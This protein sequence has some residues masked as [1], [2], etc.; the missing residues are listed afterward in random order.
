MAVELDAGQ[1][2]RFQS[3]VASAEFES[4]E[5]AYKVAL[6]EVL[7]RIL[8]PGA[9]DQPESAQRLADFFRD[10]LDLAE[11]G[12]SSEDADAIG[13]A[14]APLGGI[15]G[16]FANLCG[17]R[18]GVNNFVWIPGAI[19]AGLG[20]PTLEAFARLVDEGRP[21]ADRV[22]QFRVDL[23]EVEERAAGGSGWQEQWHVIDIQLAFVAALLGAL[24]PQRYTFYQATLLREAV[25]R[26]GG[27]WPKG[28]AG[29]RYAAICEFV[30][31]VRFQLEQ[32]GAS[33]RDLIDVQSFLFL[34]TQEGRGEERTPRVWIVRAG[35]HGEGEEVALSNDAAVI[36]WRELPDLSGYPDFP[37]IKALYTEQFP[38][39]SPQTISKQAS[40]IDRFVHELRV[41]DFVLLPRVLE[42]EVVAVGEV[43]GDYEYHPEAPFFDADA[44]H[45]RPVD[46][47]DTAVPRSSFDRELRGRLGLTGT[48][49]QI[50]LSDTSDRVRRALGEPSTE[51][52]S[53]VSY[54]WVNQGKSFDRSRT[55][56][57]L[58]APREGAGGRQFAHWLNMTKVAVGDIVLHYSSGYLRA[59]GRVTHEAVEADRPTSQ[60]LQWD[61]RG[62]VVQ[63]DYLDLDPTIPLE[64]IPVEWR[65]SERGPFA[66]TGQV[67]QGYLFPLSTAFAE[68]LAG[69]F[70]QV[71][72]AFDE[73]DGAPRRAHLWCIY[74]GRGVAANLDIGR[75]AGV[76]GVRKPD[77]LRDLHQG[78]EVLLVHDLTSD[79]SP[80]PPG[81]PRVGLQDFH[82][83][84][85]AVLR[86]TITGEPFTDDTPIWPDA[87]YPDRFRFTEQSFDHQVP[88]DEHHLET[89][90][91]D[92]IRRSA[93]DGGCPILAG[94]LPD[95]PAGYV[96][97]EFETIEAQIKA[98]GL[99]MSPQT[100]RRYH[101]SLKTRGF[102]ILSG[103]SGSGKTWLS[104]AYANA[105][106]ARP[107]LVAVAPNWTTNE[108]LLGYCNPLDQTAMWTPSSAR[109]S[110]R[111]HANTNRLRSTSAP[112]SRIT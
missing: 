42:P 7:L 25:E 87:T 86:A 108:D 72:A 62:W 23:R 44:V 103:L 41:G 57:Y 93:L 94:S 95:L 61:E 79:V 107:L 97:P 63:L 85:T 18:W 37:A 51:Q 13:S 9:L 56:G 2:R 50:H 16:A 69:R 65:E 47:L 29:T 110:A 8:D 58:W 45:T 53:G 105:V 81:F 111:R 76:W 26:Y 98:E 48:V 88:V 10:R 91:L 22:D 6:H 54:W 78:D 24:D 15:R 82:G 12:F 40:Q 84:A 74:A 34:T 35:Q 28:S 39:D 92:A 73:A 11:L 112:R 83:V 101:L 43:V 99:E 75:K 66:R 64:T 77:R 96:E 1:A 80:A 70:P 90:V 5:R 59:V 102:V 52:Q 89:D 46:W 55:G 36:G 17:G 21:L 109:S 20:Q 3:L 30:Q 71:Q 68:Q 32:H 14:A 19:D 31:A 27:E 4:E 33:T 60:D 100:L 49:A 38:T 67:N 106:E 104:Q